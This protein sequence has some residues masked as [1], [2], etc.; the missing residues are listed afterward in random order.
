M[1][2]RKCKVALLALAPWIIR[3]TNRKFWTS[4]TKCFSRLH[5]TNLIPVLC[6]VQCR[7]FEEHIRACT[8]KFA[9]LF[10]QQGFGIVISRNDVTGDTSGSWKS[11]T[12]RRSNI[13]TLVLDWAYGWAPNRWSLHFLF[14]CVF[15]LTDNLFHWLIVVHNLMERRTYPVW[16]N[17]VAS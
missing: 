16:V 4:S 17:F 13:R 14:D 2:E 6:T 12:T 11:A 1:D 9:L 8:S 10:R 3:I 15:V 5:C 7:F